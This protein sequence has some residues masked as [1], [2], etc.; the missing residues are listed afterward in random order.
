[1]LRVLISTCATPLSGSEAGWV[2]GKQAPEWDLGALPDRGRSGRAAARQ[3]GAFGPVKGLEATLTVG[4]GD[5]VMEPLVHPVP[6]AEQVD[7]RPAARDRAKPFVSRHPPHQLM[8][9]RTA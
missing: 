9:F 1:V 4:G 8:R 6:L 3:N 2:D 5:L 7:L